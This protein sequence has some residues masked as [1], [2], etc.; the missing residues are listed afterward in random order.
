VE[1]GKVEGFRRTDFGL[2]EQNEPDYLN[3]GKVISL[4][5]GSAEA[6]QLV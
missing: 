5:V 1:L 6:S 4:A 2:N 3:V